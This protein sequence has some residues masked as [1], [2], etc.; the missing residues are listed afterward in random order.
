MRETMGPRYFLPSVSKPS[1]LARA[2]DHGPQSAI[3]IT[4][5]GECPEPAQRCAN[6]LMAD[7]N[8]L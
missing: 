1:V 6:N 7:G 2:I 5:D 4:L 8:S 3:P